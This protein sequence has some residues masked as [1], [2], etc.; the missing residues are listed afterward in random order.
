MTEQR[1]GGWPYAALL[2]GVTG[3]FLFAVR[4]VLSPFVLYG[5]VVYLAWP[6]S[7]RPLGRRT[8]TASTALL[9]LWIIHT[10]GLLLAPFVLAVI[11]AYILGPAVDRL[12]E[13]RVPRPLGI[14]LLALPLLGLLALGVFVL[15]P[16]VGRQ[17]TEFISN[18]PAYV[19]VVE[20]WLEGARAWLIGLDVA[21]LNE[22]T[23]PD[24]RELDAQAVA[25][26]L[27]EWRE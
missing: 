25:S 8:L 11:L 17:V 3:A 22:T 4:P 5:L 9:L 18:V 6:Y 19:A 21:G 15:A 27:D 26:V 24:L 1:H 12:Q 14:G 16:A 7:D 2:L 20:G 23:V 13:Q 10:T